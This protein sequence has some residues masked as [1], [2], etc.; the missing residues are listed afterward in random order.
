MLR[1]GKRIGLGDTEKE[2]SLHVPRE[3]GNLGD[4][5]TAGCGQI[6]RLGKEGEWIFV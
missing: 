2:E 3:G 6:V 1:L 4:K 5:D